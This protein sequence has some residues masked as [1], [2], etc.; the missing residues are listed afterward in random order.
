MNTTNK[1]DCCGRQSAEAV[2]RQLAA[3]YV[4][5]AAQLNELADVITFSYPLH[6]DNPVEAEL[7]RQ[8]SAESQRVRSTFG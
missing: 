4:K 2:A 6:Q 1:I 8:L 5:R 3:L 7:W